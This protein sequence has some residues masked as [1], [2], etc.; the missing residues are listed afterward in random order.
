MRLESASK[1]IK[2]SSIFFS[3]REQQGSVTQHRFGFSFP[4]FRLLW[5]SYIGSAGTEPRQLFCNSP[6]T[7][8]TANLH[9]PTCLQALT[10]CPPPLHFSQT[11]TEKFIMYPSFRATVCDKTPP[12]LMTN[13]H[14]RA[15]SEAQSDRFSSLLM[16]HLSLQPPPV[17]VVTSREWT[18]CDRD[19]RPAPAQSCQDKRERGKKKKKIHMQSLLSHILKDNCTAPDPATLF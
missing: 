3:V 1:S 14:K 11:Q 6:S 13:L 7:S 8:Y 10:P 2:P 15:H 16:S 5:A 4:D 19:K 9:T 18:E 17:S 12:T